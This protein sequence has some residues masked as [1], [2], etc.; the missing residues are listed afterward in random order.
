MYYILYNNGEWCEGE[1]TLDKTTSY[2]KESNRYE[3]YGHN[4]ARIIEGRIAYS[5]GKKTVERWEDFT[6]E[7]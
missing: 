2:L 3:N 7:D 4:G 5:I 1:D 6:D